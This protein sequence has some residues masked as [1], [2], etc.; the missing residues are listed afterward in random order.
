METSVLESSLVVH[1]GALTQEEFLTTKE[2]MKLFKIKHRQTIYKLIEKGLPKIM[3]GNSYRF[4][5]QEI[6]NF[7]KN[8]SRN[9]VLEKLQQSAKKRETKRPP[10]IR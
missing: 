3:V 1:S 7:F 2:L 6:I 4:I 5:K 8:T 10:A 9:I